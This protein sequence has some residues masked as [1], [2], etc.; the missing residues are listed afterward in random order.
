MIGKPNNQG[1]PSTPVQHPLR[2]RLALGRQILDGRVLLVRSRPAGAGRLWRL[3]VE[4][5]LSRRPS[6]P[7]TASPQVGSIYGGV[8]RLPVKPSAQPTLVRTQHLPPR[9]NSPWPASMLPGASL[10]VC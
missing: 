1:A 9:G 6:T 5:W 7:R 10:S 8:G 3:V 4:E 2:R